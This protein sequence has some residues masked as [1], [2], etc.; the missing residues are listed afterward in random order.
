MNRRA[1]VPSLLSL[2][3]YWALRH[4]PFGRLV[5]RNVSDDELRHLFRLANATWKHAGGQRAPH[6]EYTSG[7]CADGYIDVTRVIRFPAISMLLAGALVRK[8][9]LQLG[10]DLANV[11]DWVVG[12]DHAAATFSQNVALR[13]GAQ[14]DFAVK[15]PDKTQL[16]NR[17]VI[18][19]DARALNVE[20]LISTL[21]TVLAVRAGVRNGNP[22]PVQFAPFILTIV[23]RASIERIEDARVVSLIEYDDLLEHKTK[24]WQP[25]ECPYCAAG[26][27]RLRPKQNW[28]KLTGRG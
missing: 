13:L 4:Y 15:G 24:L 5:E 18:E 1:P 28:A 2:R 3:D 11:V 17:S 23:A 21:G 26:S 12:S 19:P 9:R 22:H 14:H 8:A 6:V 25:S 20:D 10:V 27:E 16:W 7:L